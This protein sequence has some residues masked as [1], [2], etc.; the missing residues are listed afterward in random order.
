MNVRT[1]VTAVFAL[2]VAFGLSATAKAQTGPV[3]G[4]PATPTIPGA[5]PVAP[6]AGLSEESLEDAIK[7]LDPNYKV[8]PRSDG[9][10]K[11]YTLKVTRDGWNYVLRVE[12]GP[13]NIWISAELSGTVAVQNIPASAMLAMLKANFS[14]GPTHFA[15]LP[16]GDNGV[17]VTLTRDLTRQILTAEVF[18]ELCPSS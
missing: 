10:G 9:K 18:K 16:L 11:I 4:T 3:G 2:F 8:T 14:I 12:P 13:H 17:M 5:A 1:F 15:F 7:A 6:A